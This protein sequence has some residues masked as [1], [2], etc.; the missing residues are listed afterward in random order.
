MV[1]LKS[2]THGTAGQR[3]RRWASAQLFQMRVAVS[4][5]HLGALLITTLRWAGTLGDGRSSQH[6]TPRCT[7]APR[8]SR[9]WRH[10]MMGDLQASSPSW[11][12]GAVQLPGRAVLCCCGRSSCSASYIARI[13]S[14]LWCSCMAI[15]ETLRR[16][17]PLRSE[18]TVAMC[19]SRSAPPAA[20][21]GGRRGRRH[22]AS[23]GRAGAARW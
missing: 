6:D 21:G 20:G 7:L 16:A 22:A 13:V 10:S 19:G 12:A 11:A 18:A 1:T 3:Q 17:Q 23:G 9:S 15:A 2:A 5:N 14:T 4:Y 8:P